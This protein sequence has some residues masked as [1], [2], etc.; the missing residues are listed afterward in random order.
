MIDL[1][2]WLTKYSWLQDRRLIDW[3][4]PCLHTCWMTDWLTN[5]CLFDWLTDWLTHWFKNWLTAWLI[6]WLIKWLV[7]WLID[8]LI[9]QSIDWLTDWLTGWLTD[10]PTNWQIDWLIDWYWWRKM[11]RTRM[12]DTD[13]TKLHKSAWIWCCMYHVTLLCNQPLFGLCLAAMIKS[14]MFVYARCL[15]L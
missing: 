1:T 12:S 7:G 10:W 3:Q 4:I 11:E 8:W 15:T 9:D 2:D 5:Y 14:W 13:V 6:D